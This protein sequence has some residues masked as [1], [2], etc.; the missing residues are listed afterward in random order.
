MA[1]HIR[2][3]RQGAKKNPFYRIIVAD[4]A[5]PRDGRFLEIVGTYDPMK[6]KA[7]EGIRLKDDRIRY[8]LGV[9]ALPTDTVRSL[10]QRH[11]YYKRIL[12]SAPAA[13]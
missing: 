6:E 3:T 5:M 8:W 1:V 4:K 9:G 13:S 10:L 7:E 11:G 12:A 2:L